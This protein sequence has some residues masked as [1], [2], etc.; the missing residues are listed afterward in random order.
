M[1]MYLNEGY[2]LALLEDCDFIN[3]NKEINSISEL[4]NQ[5]TCIIES[6]AVSNFEIDLEK[7]GMLKDVFFGENLLNLQKYE[8]THLFYSKIFDLDD[9]ED[10][11]TIVFEG[12]DTYATIYCN[13]E[14]IGETD[15]MLISHSLKVSN[16][17]KTGNELF[18][19]ITP[20][21]I[22]AR[23]YDNPAYTYALK[24]NY[25]AM[26]VRK[27]NYMNGWD[28]FPRIMS[29]GIWKEVYL[30]KAKEIG[31]TQQY[32]YT[33]D[34][35]SDYSN[36]TIQFF[37]E[38]ELKR[39]A[40]S[41]FFVEIK[42][43]CKNSVFSK[44][45]RVWSKAGKLTLEVE[46]PYLWWPRN[47]G[48]QNLYEVEAIL[49]QGENIVDTVNIVF[50][51][52][53]VKLERT[54]ITDINSSG[55]FC[56]KINGKRVFI[57]G[58]NWVPL[59]SFP[60]QGKKKLKEAMSLV[61]DIGCNMIRCWGGGYY[62]DEEFYE[63]C[64]RKGLLVWQ[65]FMLGCGLYPQDEEFLQRLKVELIQIIKRLRQHSSLVLW[66]GDNE[67]D[68]AC[69]W[70]GNI[71][72]PNDNVITR[73]LMPEMV[74]MHDFVRDFLPSSPYMDEES[75]LHGSD[76]ITENHLWGPRDYFKSD[77]YKNALAHFASE[78]GYHG[79]PSVES[80]KKFISEK[81]LWPYKNNREWLLHASSPTVE[82]DEPYA[83]RIDL[84]ANQIQVLF[85]NIPDNITDFSLFSQI[86]QA[87]AKKYFIERFRIGK[88]N[89][90]GIIWWNILDGCPQFSDAVV[91][92]YFE[93]K[94]A[95]HYIKRSQQTVCIMIDESDT[96]SNSVVVV[97]DSNENELLDYKIISSKTGREVLCGSVLATGDNV[98][99]IGIISNLERGDILMLYWENSHINGFN[100]YLVGEAP[101]DSS[102][103]IE[104]AKQKNLLNN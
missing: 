44:K 76:Y 97:N 10:F 39:H 80:V 19:H 67:C 52:R 45:E 3:L 30:C 32:L 64:D 71:I 59:D 4:D 94:L 25:D 22:K 85:G 16:L 49:Y 61:E 51:L 13:G 53:T 9:Q 88:W 1:K 81:S 91:D 66:A 72:N 12:L 90:T 28:I 57:L 82:I 74:R 20:V 33:I 79:C 50:G 99:E 15:N 89:R 21:A 98:T 37:Y 101:F 68:V 84:M 6:S 31:F 5:K 87:E 35:S 18:V 26:N 100:H 69:E 14:L 48:E 75:M 17:R 40:Y 47:S 104:L 77:F 43:V 7:A 92:Y 103:Y 56:F 93:K 55:E 60:S 54:S 46:N 73:K 23:E 65:D 62:E 34:V 83:Y 8:M 27:S 86:S 41:D 38:L 70:G 63:L 42:G 29:G 102:T 58:T 78:I 96:G 36:A 24:Y 2:T 95:Y 11:D